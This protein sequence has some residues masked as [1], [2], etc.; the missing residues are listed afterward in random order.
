MA[1]IAAQLRK[2]RKLINI[3]YTIKFVDRKI[4]ESEFE[5]KSHICSYLDIGAFNE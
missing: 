5:E 1:T 3:P 2:L 4:L